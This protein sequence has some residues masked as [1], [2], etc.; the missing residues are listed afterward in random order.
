MGE[1]ALIVGVKRLRALAKRGDRSREPAWLEPK[2]ADWRR[3]H[4]SQL[5]KT[6]RQRGLRSS[7]SH[8]EATHEMT[9]EDARR[10]WLIDRL[11]TYELHWHEKE[12]ARLAAAGQADKNKIAVPKDDL[13]GE[14]IECDIDGEALGDD[15]INGES[16][17]GLDTAELVRLIE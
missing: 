6:C 14:T 3:Q 13:D 11:V 16:L 7:T 17:A 9:F 12:Q 8:L 1:A 5:E 2:L 15:D 10:E 4:F